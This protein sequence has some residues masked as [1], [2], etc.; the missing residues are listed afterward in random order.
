MYMYE[1]LRISPLVHAEVF[2]SCTEYSQL[3]LSQISWDWRNSFDLEKI[4]LC[5]VKNN[6]KLEVICHADKL[7]D[8]LY[9]C[10]ER[11]AHMKWYGYDFKYYV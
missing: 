11:I 8:M 2:H 10:T 3:C 7:G 1:T 4:D 9:A 6:R 5:E